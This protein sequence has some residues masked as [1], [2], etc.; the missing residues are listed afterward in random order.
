MREVAEVRTRFET[1]IVH[2]CAGIMPS[3]RHIVLSPPPSDKHHTRRTNK[4][5]ITC[6]TSTENSL[7]RTCAAIRFLRLSNGLSCETLHWRIDDEFLYSKSRNR[8]VSFEFRKFH[9][10]LNADMFA[11]EFSFRPLLADHLSSAQ[12]VCQLHSLGPVRKRPCQLRQGKAFCRV[13]WQV[14]NNVS[15]CV[16]VASGS[17]GI[18]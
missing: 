1:L 12:L 6:E 17:P 7:T 4:K 2:A 18:C 3:W 13:S 8:S 15:I 11:N 10:Q 5:K 14:N 9:V 16:E